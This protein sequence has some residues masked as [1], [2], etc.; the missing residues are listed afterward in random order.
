MEKLLETFNSKHKYISLE[1]EPKQ[2]IRLGTKPY[3]QYKIYIT[4]YAEGFDLNRLETLEKEI[5]EAKSFI[6]LHELN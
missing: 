1:V 4:D 6:S 2:G 3:W 5:K